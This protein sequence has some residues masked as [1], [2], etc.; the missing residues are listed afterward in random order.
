MIAPAPVIAG[1]DGKL[2]LDIKFAEG[3][4]KHVDEWPGRVTCILRLGAS[5]IPFGKLYD[6]A[7]LGFDLQTLSPD[8]PIEVG[9]LYAGDI[10]LASADMY[11]TLKIAT[12]AQKPK[13]VKIVYS[14]ENTLQSRRNMLFLDQ[15]KSYL[16][17]LRS[18]VWLIRQ[19][20]KVKSALETCDGLQAN[21][22]PALSEY[23]KLNTNAML[24]LD[25]RMSDAMMASVG[26]MQ[27]RVDHLLSDKPLRIVH[28]G[29][30]ETIKGGQDLVPVAIAL[31]NSGLSFRLDIF[32][33]GGLSNMI[34]EAILSE[35]LDGIVKMHGP[36]DFETELV[37][38]MRQHSDVFLSC[39]RQSDP[40][41]SYLESL[42]CGVPVVGYN[43]AMW[44]TLSAKS[45]GGWSVPLGKPE[46]L[47]AK[48]IELSLDRPAI[49]KAANAG[50]TFAKGHTFEIE[51]SKRM[52][53][54]KAI[55]GLS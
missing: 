38:H 23:G 6:K 21:G 25:G 31:R 41:C 32:G 16:R 3:M 44:S 35:G 30:L 52:D 24:Y 42:G 33:S 55:A 50:L 53:H 51:F 14:I 5:Q 15:Q 37:P 10:I 13:G 43:N 39:H 29:R 34:E 26:E 11:D 27:A 19:E 4:Q 20:R 47:A 22:Y 28:S 2:K 48:I 49:A 45:R 9:D 46:L 7:D 12:A 8:A 17:K 18:F 40:S 1:P 54:L 36:I